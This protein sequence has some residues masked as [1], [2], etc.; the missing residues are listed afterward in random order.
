MFKLFNDIIQNKNTYVKSKT[1]SEKEA[2]NSFLNDFCESDDFEDLTLE[3]LEQSNKPKKIINNYNKKDFLN[4]FA[5]NIFSIILDSRKDKNNHNLVNT[6]NNS[7]FTKE[8]DD[9]SFSI[10]I[11]DLF[12]YNDFY[13]DKN[14]IQKFVM[15]FYLIKNKKN[16][17]IKT[18]VE[19]WK[20]SYK[21]NDDNETINNN[22]MNNL[23]N[24]ISILKKSIITYSRILPLYHYIKL[25]NEE[26]DYS[27]DFKFYNNNLKKKGEFLNKPSGNVSLKNSNLF[28]FKLN[29]KYYSEKEI[30]N[31]FDETGEDEQNRHRFKSLSFN[32]KKSTLNQFETIINNNETNP[33]NKENDNYINKVKTCQ[34]EV[35]NKIKEEDSFTNSSFILSI[36]DND[37]EENKNILNLNLNSQIEN[38]LNK[39]NKDN[40]ENLCKR[41]CSN[42]SNS[43]EMT[44]D[45]TPRNNESKLYDNKDIKK[46]PS[47]SK[48]TTLNRSNNKEVNNIFKEYNIL[49][50]M[51]QNYSSNIITKNKK[52]MTYMDVFE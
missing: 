2:P 33:I 26:N 25:A 21:L 28:S 45:C 47:M 50:E 23:K 41:K 32:Q 14:D 29:I 19:K 42:F 9:K 49:K 36:H 48:K 34:I 4:D 35:N 38:A 24:K 10:D 39:K 22:D 30:K 12:L 44:E 7:D 11:D 52:L 1:I 18:L 40:D 27:I 17:K 6:S 16:K 8:Y 13:K 5:K 20:I 3:S 51:M 37:K 15:E 43:Y 31:I 46:I